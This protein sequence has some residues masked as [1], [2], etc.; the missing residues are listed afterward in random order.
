M[1]HR[2]IKTLVEGMAEQALANM[3]PMQTHSQAGWGVAQAS[4]A[5]A[6]RT[7]EVPCIDPLAK[8]QESAVNRPSSLPCCGHGILFR[9][10][11]ALSL[12]RESSCVS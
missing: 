5:S 9:A 12:R 6:S 2:A 4:F 7:Y 10:A 8:F 1:L 3:F 11:E